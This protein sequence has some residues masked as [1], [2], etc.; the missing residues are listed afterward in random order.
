MPFTEEE[1][2]EVYGKQTEDM[3]KYLMKEVK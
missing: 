1:K 2:N 3:I